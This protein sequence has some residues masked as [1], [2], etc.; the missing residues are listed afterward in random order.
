MRERLAIW[1]LKIAPKSVKSIIFSSRSTRPWFS[2]S[3]KKKNYTSIFSRRS[4]EWKSKWYDC[5]NKKN[6]KSDVLKKKTIF[7]IFFFFFQNFPVLVP[8]KRGPSNIFF[9]RKK[10]KK[11]LGCHNPPTHAY[12]IISFFLLFSRL[13]SFSCS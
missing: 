9:R 4:V 1:V 13:F 3:I 10:K 5:R 8:Q 11:L 2:S 6:N 7:W 12:S